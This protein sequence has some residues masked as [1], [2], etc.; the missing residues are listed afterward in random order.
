VK[1]SPA[2][3][4]PLHEVPVRVPVKPPSPT[5]FTALPETRSPLT[6]LPVNAVPGLIVT[7][8]FHEMLKVVLVSV[9][10]YFAPVGAGAVTGAAATAADG[11]AA[12]G[13][14]FA[15]AAGAYTGVGA[16]TAAGAVFAT[17]AA[18]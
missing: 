3:V 12:A 10:Q 14:V 11:V 17:G 8:R 13:D 16:A 9:P 7:T 5:L 15:T 2:C 1:T 4:V 18:A 6:M